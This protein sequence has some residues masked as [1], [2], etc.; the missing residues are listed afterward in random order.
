[1]AAE[2]GG[3]LPCNSRRTPQSFK[4]SRLADG[5][6]SRVPQEYRVPEWHCVVHEYAI[7]VCV[8]VRRFRSV[9]VGPVPFL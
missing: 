8:S 7:L 5:M 9:R 1:M 2:E 3:S 4:G 6:N